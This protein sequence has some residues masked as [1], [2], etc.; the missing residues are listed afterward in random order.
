MGRA[1]ISSFSMWESKSKDCLGNWQ[2]LTSSAPGPLQASASTRTQPPISGAVVGSGWSNCISFLILV[3]P[4]P[5]LQTD[6]VNVHWIW[7]VVLWGKGVGKYHH[8][9][10]VWWRRVELETIPKDAHK[11]CNRNSEWVNCSSSSPSG[12]ASRTAARRVLLNLSQQ[13]LNW[14]F[15]PKPQGL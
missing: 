7:M 14:S 3:V 11:L 4:C 9:S 15:T 8:C 1:G 5:A 10:S 2:C 6:D 13:E 12:Y